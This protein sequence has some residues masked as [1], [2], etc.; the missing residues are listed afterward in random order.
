MSFMTPLFPS[1]KALKKAYPQYRNLRVTDSVLRGRRRDDGSIEIKRTVY[2][3]SPK[4]RPVK[5]FPSSSGKR[6][7]TGL[8]RYL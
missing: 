4:G 8:D 2:V 6:R 5:D 1:I 7:Y 3:L